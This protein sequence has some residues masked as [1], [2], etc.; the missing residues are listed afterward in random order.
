MVRHSCWM[1]CTRSVASSHCLLVF[2]FFSSIAFSSFTSACFFSRFS[3]S[4]AW[5][6]S[7]YAWCFL[8]ITVDACLKRFHSSSLSSRA[9]G[10][11]S[12]HSSCNCCNARLASTMFGCSCSFSAA[13]QST[14]F[15]SR[16]FLKSKSRNSILIFTRS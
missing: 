9:T 15:S 5:S 10:P 4:F 11:I 7:K 14:V 8:L 2:S 1:A 6:S 3:F 12:A 16:F 13:S